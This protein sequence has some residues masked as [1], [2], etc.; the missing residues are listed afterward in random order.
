MILPG[1][2]ETELARIIQERRTIRE[3]NGNPLDKATVTAILQAAVW[4]PFHSRKE[5]W[6]FILFMG[7]GR[8]TFANAVALT[9][10]AEY[11]Q[12]WG[13]WAYNQYCNLMQAHMVVAFEADP[14]Q[15]FWEDAFS[16]TA[17]LIQNI[18]LLSW[19]RGVGTVWKTNECNWDPAFHKAVGINSNE[20]IAGILHLGYFDKIPKPRKRTPLASLLTYVDEAIT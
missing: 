10:S 14:R 4:A 18:Q 1:N 9:Y 16:A 3:F 11:K 20:R 13:E 7:E 17:A 15:K 8:K 5:P 2:A 6:R 12:R 19:E